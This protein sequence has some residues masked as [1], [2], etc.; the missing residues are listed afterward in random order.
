MRARHGRSRVER[1]GA[2]TFRCQDANSGSSYVGLLKS[3]SF[4]K[5]AIEKRLEDYFQKLSTLIMPGK[6]GLGPLEEKAATLGDSTPFPT[7]LTAREIFTTGVLRTRN[8]LTNKPSMPEIKQVECLHLPR[9]VGVGP[10]PM[11]DLE[12]HEHARQAIADEEVLEEVVVLLRQ[13]E[14]FGTCF[15]KSFEGVNESLRRWVGGCLPRRGAQHDLTRH[16]RRC[17]L[18]FV[19]A[20]QMIKSTLLTEGP[21]Q[22]A[23]Y[24][25]CLVL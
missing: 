21:M 3:T 25:M 10:D 19:A 1:V 14:A 15:H 23:K 22:L 9:A 17:E 13:D 6:L 4:H 12:V 18:I 7:T 16:V 20:E 5:P 11:C 24:I 2:A 8:S